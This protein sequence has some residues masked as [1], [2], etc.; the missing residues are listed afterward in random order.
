MPSGLKWYSVGQFFIDGMPGNSSSVG[1][2]VARAATGDYWVRETREET[3]VESFA[4]AT[5]VVDLV[6]GYGGGLEELRDSLEGLEKLAWV[7]LIARQRLGEI[8]N[9]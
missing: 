3:Q 9:E 5:D 6:E 7:R 1:I 8:D 4:S 2:C